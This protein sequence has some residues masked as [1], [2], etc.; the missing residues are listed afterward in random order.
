MEL[1]TD[2]VE[3]VKKLIE[4]WGFEYGLKADETKVGALAA[5]LGLDRIVKEL[6]QE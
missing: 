6:S 2:E 5:K 3:T 1:S 4:D